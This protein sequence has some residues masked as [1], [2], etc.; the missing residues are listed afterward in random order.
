MDLMTERR[1]AHD[2]TLSIFMNQYDSRPGQPSPNA[3]AFADHLPPGLR[4]DQIAQVSYNRGKEEAFQRA[5]KV[6]LKLIKQMHDRGVQLL[7]GTDASLPGFV[8]VSE[9]QYYAQAGIANTDILRLATLGA[10]RYLGQDGELGSVTEG[11][12]AY[13]MLVDGDPTQELSA[14]RKVDR[15][16]KSNAVFRVRQILEAQ[17]IA[18]F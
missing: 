16:I 13:L 18:P 6:A 2:P 3:A 9:L 4:R 14:L 15:V 12:K 10:A 7:P 17:G 11:K 8:L 1:I 5:G